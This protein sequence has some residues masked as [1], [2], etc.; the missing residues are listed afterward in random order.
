MEKEKAIIVM[1]IRERLLS[2][3]ICCNLAPEEMKE[4]E[5]EVFNLLPPPGTCTT[6]WS[7]NWDIEPVRCAEQEGFWH[8]ICW[9]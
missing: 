1:T 2:M 7:V 3:Q 8:Y 9:L 5:Q 6:T 4:R